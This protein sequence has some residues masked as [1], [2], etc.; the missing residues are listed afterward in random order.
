ME[1]KQLDIKPE[2]SWLKRTF[3]AKHTKKTILYIVLGALA[4]FVYFWFAEEKQL[5]DFTTGEI[6]KSM[7]FGGLFG[8]LIT[9]NPCARNK[10]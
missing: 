4:G 8:F 3:E 2:G 10:C 1:F 6:L 9:N 5:A 7:F